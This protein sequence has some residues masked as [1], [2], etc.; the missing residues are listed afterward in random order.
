[1][2]VMRRA[3]GLERERRGLQALFFIEVRRFGS[4]SVCAGEMSSS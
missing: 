2:D 1:M 3:G 4:A